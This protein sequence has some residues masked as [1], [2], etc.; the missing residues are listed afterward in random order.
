MTDAAV[1][2]FGD[3]IAPRR[4]HSRPEAAALVEVLRALEHHPA[5]AWVRRMNSG[6]ARIDGRRIEFGWP[7][8][9][10]LIGMTKDGRTIACEVKGPDG[11][12]RPEQ[13]RFLEMVNAHGGIGFVAR[14]CKDVFAEL[15]PPGATSTTGGSLPT[16]IPHPRRTP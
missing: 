15:G 16:L 12:L 3:E 5:V 1:D 13:T 6:V 10:D 9:P 8:A 14:S 4:H 2:L 7:G 11:R